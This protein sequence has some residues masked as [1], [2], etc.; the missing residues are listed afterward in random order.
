MGIEERL[1]Y[2]DSLVSTSKYE[3]QKRTLE[4]NF[5][6]F[7]GKSG[8][9]N[10]RDSTPEDVRRF[11]VSK[12]KGGKTIIH[13]LYCKNMGTQE[14]NCSCPRRL[15]IGTVKSLLG[16]LLVIFEGCGKRGP[17]HGIGPFDGGNP[18]DSEEVRQYVKA[19]QKEQSL[20]HVE[21]KQAIP[22]FID[23]LTKIS[24]HIL[25]VLNSSGLKSADIFIGLRDRAFFLLQYFA[26]DRAGDLGRVVAQ[27]V[28][29]LP[30]NEGLLFKHRVGKTLSNGK[31][32]VFAI[33]RAEDS[34]IC[35]VTA[36]DDYVEGARNMGIN[37]AI[38]FLF[39][40]IDI[41]KSGV[42][43]ESLSYSVAYDRLKHYLKILDI[44]E[45]ETPHSLRRGCAIS[46][47]LSGSASQAQI[48][49]H[50]GWFSESSLRRY[51]ELPNI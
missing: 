36:L 49:N 14:K 47:S 21:V 50:I 40:P 1:R 12:D 34:S 16:K 48:M 37:L 15:A 23:K 43:E 30:N 9:Y 25:S 29:R 33:K 18:V 42:L 51:N 46:L 13:S 19:I 35:P 32:N 31:A 7:L 20:A 5:L 22:M 11:L 26:G 8:K 44:D 27:E 4:S 28:K 24:H 41:S 3:K 39:R 6:S 45:G 10:L 38:G 2:L 17:W